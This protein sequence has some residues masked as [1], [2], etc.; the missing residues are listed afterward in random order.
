MNVR[1]INPFLEASLLLFRKYLG[2]D[3]HNENPRLAADPNNLLEVSA[4]IGLTGDARGAIVLSFSRET[5]IRMVSVF[6]ERQYQALGK[7][8]I[9]GV[10]ELV[11]IIAGNAKR[12]L[13]MFRLEISLP[14]VITGNKYKIDWPMGVPVITIPFTSRLGNFRVYVSLKD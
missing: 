13:T 12:G 6:A 10:G 8:V 2:L 4:I 1:Y 9:D 3:L 11:N 7:D 5:A 14:G